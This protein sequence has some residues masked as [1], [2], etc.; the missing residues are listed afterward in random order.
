[1][2]VLDNEER[3]FDAS[4]KEVGRVDYAVHRWT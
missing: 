2:R 4:N 3:F 1:M